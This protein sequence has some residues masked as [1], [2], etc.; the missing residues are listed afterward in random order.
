VAYNLHEPVMQRLREPGVPF[1]RWML[2]ARTIHEWGHLAVEAG[3]VPVPEQRR[4][5]HAA[6]QAELAQ[7]FDSIVAESPAALRTHA[8]TRLAEL[9]AR[10]GSAGQALVAQILGRMSDW[11][12]NLLAQR[13]LSAEERETYVRNNVRPLLSELDSTQLF[14]AL[15]RYAFE[16]QYLAFS[17]SPAP[18]AVFLASTW[19][20]EQFLARGVLGESR[21]EELLDGVGRL[22]RCHELDA[23]RFRWAAEPPVRTSSA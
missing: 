1:E 15:A 16:Y 7:L 3:W 5:E 21:L 11:Q 10:T 18:R 14:Q 9:R 8:A 23:S 4:G 19:F 2:G 17:S 13:Y 22:C 12:S 20:S 6:V